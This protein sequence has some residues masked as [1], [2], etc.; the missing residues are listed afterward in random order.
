MTY[1]LISLLILFIYFGMLASAIR[2]LCTNIFEKTFNELGQK[3][4]FTIVLIIPSLLLIS[5]SQAFFDLS[6][7]SD[8]FSSSELMG[9]QARQIAFHLGGSILGLVVLLVLGRLFFTNTSTEENHSGIFIGLALI[10]I[11]LALIISPFLFQVLTDVIPKSEI[12]G[13]R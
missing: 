2:F 3:S 9:R 5:L 4:V 13:F 7:M 1:Q 8:F 11:V 10:A 12:Q 6:Q